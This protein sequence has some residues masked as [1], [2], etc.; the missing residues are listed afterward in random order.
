MIAKTA[1]FDRR[2]VLWGGSALLATALAGCSTTGSTS[3]LRIPITGKGESDTRLLFRHAGLKPDFPVAY[4]EFQSGQLV[5]EAFNSGSLDFGGTSEIPPVFAAASAVQ[6][7]R[8]I[9][10]LRGDVNNQV[11]LVPKGSP[12]RTLADLKGKR[13]GYVRATTSQYFLIRML[14]SVGLAWS[15]IEPV[16]MTVPDGAAAFSRGSLDAWA[17]YGFPIQRAQ[18][19]E[20]ARVLKT[21]LGFLSGNYIMSAH[22]D[23]IADKQ[24]S[25]WIGRYLGLLQKGY[26]WAAQNKD[27]WA[28]IVAADIGVDAAYVRDQFHHC[29]A[30]YA[31]RPVTAD[32]IGSQQQVADVFT[33]AG[34]IPR[35]VDIRPLW[36][37]SFNPVILKE[38]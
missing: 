8:Q 35:R 13:V 14:S 33:K 9:A 15:D 30:D 10:V 1:H 22:I 3:A 18:A 32:A 23:A 16:A 28:D 38:I 7:F 24:K 25:E 29:S 20:G 17:I 2:A 34:L 4:S 19:T 6:N 12:I 36:V 31:L 26:H 37:D 5:I 21:A 11:V 27:L